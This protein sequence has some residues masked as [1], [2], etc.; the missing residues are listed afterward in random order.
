MFKRKVT[1]LREEARKADAAADALSNQ[2]AMHQASA[3]VAQEGAMKYRAEFLEF[4]NEIIGA[5]GQE[6]DDLNKVADYVRDMRRKVDKYHHIINVMND[7][8]NPDEQ[9]LRRMA[10]ALGTSQLDPNTVIARVDDLTTIKR[11]KQAVERKLERA[12][13][14]LKEAQ[15][16]LD[17][18]WGSRPAI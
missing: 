18:I 16:D 2:C 1:K 10:C 15:A 13:N 5:T 6:F 9:L 12:T 14:E 3:E 17:D 7:K 8:F 11:E 4:A